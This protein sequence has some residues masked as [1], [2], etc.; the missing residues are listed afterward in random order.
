[1]QWYGIFVTLLRLEDDAGKKKSG[2][3]LAQVHGF[4]NVSKGAKDKSRSKASISRVTTARKRGDVLLIPMRE[5]VC[6]SRVQLAF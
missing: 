2:E 1:M 5:T 3:K 6:D 4:A